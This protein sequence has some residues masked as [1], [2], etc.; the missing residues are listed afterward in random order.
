MWQELPSQVAKL[1][2]P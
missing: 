1:P 2:P